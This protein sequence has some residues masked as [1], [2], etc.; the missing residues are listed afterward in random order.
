MKRKT[1]TIEQLLYILAFLLALGVRLLRLGVPPLSDFEATWALQALGISRGDAIFLGTQPLYVFFTGLAFTLLGSGNG[2]ARLFPLV[3]G[4]VLV[5]VPYLWSRGFDRFR[6]AALIAAF[7]L[8]LDPGLV[9]SSRLAGSPAPVL[10]FLLLA[11]GFTLCHSAA[12]TGFFGGLALLSGVPV[13][14]GLISLIVTWGVAKW[15]ESHGVLARLSEVE[16]HS[17]NV[18]SSVAF[19]RTAIL[20]GGVTILATGTFLSLIPQGI[21]SLADTFTAYLRGWVRPSGVLVFR[22][23]AVLFI[24]QPLVLFLGIGGSVRGW[25]MREPISQRLSL[26]TIFAF[27]FVLI[28]PARQSLDLVWVLVPLWILAAW[29]FQHHIPAIKESPGILWSSLEF[30]LGVVVL[31]GV[32]WL[33]LVAG[34]VRLVVLALAMLA[35]IALMV[36]MWSYHVMRYGLVWGLCG[37]LLVSMVV[38]MFGVAQVNPNGSQELWSVTPA[39]GDVRLLVNTLENL[40]QWKT[41]ER[42]A[43]DVAVVSNSRELRWLLRDFHAARY[44]PDFSGAGVVDDDAPSVLI[45]HQTQNIPGLPVLYR[46][47][48]FILYTYPGWSSVL[49]ENWVNW[50]AYREAPLLQD[51]VI[52]WA[53]TDLF[54]GGLL[55]KAIVTSESASSPDLP[56]P[57]DLDSNV[58]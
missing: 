37:A 45:T 46:G 52:L 44:V 50:L 13:L 9:A 28:Y 17:G 3:T 4:S 41:G 18:R 25:R 32:A 34:E 12:W 11:L 15:L 16:S 24:Y 21:A 8:A 20:V 23:V 54:P 38:A 10:T 57:S 30:G 40:S 5:F 2:L 43:I 31:L 19:I 27:V 7:G 51:Q 1:L 36:A 56:L 22:L 48:D 33:G 58:P 35:A 55:Q 49:P 39:T 14:P 26:W 47:Q 53:R 42:Q 6:L 29:E